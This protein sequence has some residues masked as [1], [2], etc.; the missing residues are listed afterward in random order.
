MA[1]LF[2]GWLAYQAW[3]LR[4]VTVT[5]QLP[6]GFGLEPGDEVRYRGIKVGEVRRVEL[7]EGLDGIRI[8]AALHTEADRL[9]CSGSRYWVVRPQLGPAGVA[10]LETL[11]GPRYLAVLPGD[12]PRRRHAAETSTSSPV[13]SSR[14][15]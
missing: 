15:S 12:G 6:E 7:A 11:I 8:T 9:A 14:K 2:A 10:G 1:L 13:S 3:S 4:G 5:V